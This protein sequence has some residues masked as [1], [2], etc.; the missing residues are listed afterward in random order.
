MK[1]YLK[2]LLYYILTGIMLWYCIIL[3]SDAQNVKQGIVESVNVCM[4]VIIPSL[5]AFMAASGLIVSSGAYVILSK[6]FYILSKHLIK[7]PWELFGIFLISNFAGY[8]IGAKL[9]C[10]LYDKK[11][12]DSKTAKTMICFCF[13]A[14]PGFIGSGIGLAVFGSIRVGMIIFISCALSNLMLAAVMCR[15]FKPKIEK[16]DT[17]LRFDS[18]ILTD[19]VLSAGRSLLIVCVF[20]VFFSTVMSVLDHYGIIGQLG[21]IFTIP[22]SETFVRA[23]LEIS[24]ITRVSNNS[25]EILPLAAVMCSFGGICVILQVKALTGKRFD[26]KPFLLTRPICCALSAIN[27]LWIS[28]LML[29]DSLEAFASDSH[30]FVKVNNFVPSVCLILMIF[31]LKIKKR[32]AFLKRV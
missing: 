8:P 9:L 28:R 15:I 23:F 3:I 12:I 30:I 17:H 13:G 7:M 5:F 21:S 20:I 26:L 16:E 19:S 6:P 27:T 25:F 1:A 4:N 2:E 11:K 22:N 32:V 10:D 31:L 18:Q 14:G 29:P 24:N